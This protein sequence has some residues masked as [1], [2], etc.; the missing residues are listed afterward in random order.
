[1]NGALHTN[2]QGMHELGAVVMHGV[3]ATNLDGTLRSQGVEEGGFSYVVFPFPR[4]TL[5]RATEPCNSALLQGFFRSVAEGGFLLPGGLVQMVMLSSQYEEWDV[6]NM[7]ADS[8]FVLLARAQLPH[9]FYQSREMS[10]K[11]WSPTG[12]EL[13]NFGLEYEQPQLPQVAELG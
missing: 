9:D 2:L 10:G 1:M 12:A 11:P 13:L 8:G 5:S 7:A 6:A 3:D 4:A